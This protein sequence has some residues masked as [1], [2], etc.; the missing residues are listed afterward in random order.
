[1]PLGLTR[2]SVM[3]SGGRWASEGLTERDLR[4]SHLPRNFSGSYSGAMLW[5]PFRG[6]KQINNL[7]I[8]IICYL[9]QDRN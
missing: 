6:A 2:D 4:R 1:M 8:F 3:E 5:G 9:S 7:L